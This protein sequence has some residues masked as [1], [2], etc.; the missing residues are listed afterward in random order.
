MLLFV[1][2]KQT[3]LL[4]VF[5]LVLTVAGCDTSKIIFRESS[6]KSDFLEIKKINYAHCG[7]AHVYAEKYIGGRKFFSITYRNEGTIKSIYRYNSSG[8]VS[9]TVI[10]K[11]VNTKDFSISLDTIDSIIFNKIDS[12]TQKTQDAPIYRLERPNIK[13]YVRKR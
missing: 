12:F 8:N 2:L 4:N 6:S 7:C 11:G 10:L 5:V 1:M 13:G 9:D 3:N